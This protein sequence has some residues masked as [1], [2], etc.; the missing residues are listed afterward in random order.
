MSKSINQII[1]LLLLLLF[2][3]FLVF[4]V[5]VVVVIV[6]FCFHASSPKRLKATLGKGLQE[7][8]YLDEHQG[9]KGRN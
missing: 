6:C 4:C 9:A 3:L 8:K 1:V 2:L 7:E 5:V